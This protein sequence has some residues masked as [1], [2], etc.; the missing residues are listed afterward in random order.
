MA[1]YHLSAKPIS[2]SAGRSAT[3]AAAYRAGVEITDERTGVVHDYTRKGG[4]MHSELILPGGGTA[5][6]AEFWNDIE[7]HHKRGDAVL[8]REVEVSLPTEL[9]AEQRQGLAVGYAREL[10]DRYGVAVDV[11]LH[12]PRTITDRELAKNPDQ[13]HETDPDT[14]RRHNGNWHAHV[15]L[16][17]C[18]VEPDGTL[19]KKAVE[20]DPIHCQRAKIDNMVDRER[21]R[22]GELANAALERHGHTARIDH[23]SH[24]ARG[25]EAEPTR[26]LGPAAASIERRT[27][28]KSQKRIGWE[29]DAADRLTRASE[30]GQL[31]RERA[32]LASS[33][34]DLS[35]DLNAAKAERDAP[36]QA[37]MQQITR[38]SGGIN[39]RSRY[40]PDN[41]AKREQ[42][43][44]TKAI[45]E[46]AAKGQRQAEAL[47]RQAQWAA[48]TS[49]RSAAAVVGAPE[50]LNRATGVED[51]AAKVRYAQALE[52]VASETLATVPGILPPQAIRQALHQVGKEVEAE[53]SQAKDIDV[54]AI[55]R[56][57][58]AQPG[59]QYRL[60]QASMKEAQGQVTLE[61]VAS[62][63]GLKRMLY[64]TKAMTQEANELLAAAKLERA[65]VGNAVELSPEVQAGLKAN[66][67]AK[68]TRR[69]AATSIQELGEIL[70]RADAG[71]AL[72]QRPE[73]VY[74][75]SETVTRVV[76]KARAIAP[77][78]LQGM[79]LA[80]V[81][82]MTAKAVDVEWK[83]PDS[84]RE[85]DVRVSRF[86]LPAQERRQHQE[87]QQAR[88]KEGQDY[89]NS[90]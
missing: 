88:Q 4:V 2:R 76:E 11:A 32:A 42:A 89:G 63:G 78:S 81:E 3:A 58:L 27:G 84:Q 20:L 57:V 21:V 40:H 74:R 1:T 8:V 71:Q 77:N 69:Q 44:A 67:L 5:D 36:R 14:G 45:E 29:Q 68:Q 33:I 30:L 17:A 19:G 12:A 10:A 35:G 73:H 82:R 54:D 49:T 50:A 59:M 61:N 26:H 37:A 16:S 53:A 55:R 62:M 80:E 65:Q 18:R 39:P 60:S 52:N 22:W 56:Q 9:T 15:M 23:R 46:A 85:Y 25:I 64:D 7:K 38:D 87:R 48:R 79:Q 31:E 47:A 66:E 51:G 34:L 75:V 24:E 90:L 70:P 83:K 43:E 6:R 72:Y 86:V 41:I 13:Y 28:E